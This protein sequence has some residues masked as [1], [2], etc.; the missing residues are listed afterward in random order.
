M[1]KKERENLEKFM[2]SGKTTSLDNGFI[3]I[4]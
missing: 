2:K 1:W 3:I 4:V